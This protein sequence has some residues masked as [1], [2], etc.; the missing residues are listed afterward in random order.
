MSAPEIAVEDVSGEAVV[1]RRRR[2]ATRRV[3][4]RLCGTALG[5]GVAASLEAHYLEPNLIEVTRHEVFL[6]HLPLAL[7]GLTVAQ[8]TDLHRGHVTPDATI[9][10]AA[11]AT[12]EARPDLVVLTGDFVDFDPVDAAS[13]ASMLRVLKPRLGVWGCLG[14]HDYVVDADAVTANLSRGADV[15]MLRNGSHE[16][17]PGLWVAGIEDTYVG[18][19]DTT[20]ATEQIPSTAAA[21][22]LTHNPTGVFQVAKQPWLALAGHTHGGQ[23]CIPGLPP[24]RPPGMI[25]FPQVEGWGRF[26]RAW[27]YISR[28]VGM[29]A[30]P[31]RFRCRPEVAVFTLRRGDAM[32]ISAGVTLEKVVSRAER[33]VRRGLKVALR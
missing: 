15:R 33:A 14:N 30:V 9:R 24:Q 27:L 3:F 17:A 28:G 21:L 23:I 2:S 16:L 7:D 20:A 31:L 5:A 4:L 32:P 19:P 18:K 13:L 12:A 25:G 1:K 22:F 29:G 6:P 8:L 11:E 10:K 26:D